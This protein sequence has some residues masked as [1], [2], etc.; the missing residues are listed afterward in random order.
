MTAEADRARSRGENDRTRRWGELMYWPLTLA[1][2][3]FLITY[4]VHVIGDVSGI[5]RG[6]TLSTIGV[7][8]IV[9]AADY[10]ITLILSHP[11]RRWFRTHLFDL[12][13]V[14]VPALRPIRLLGALTRIASMRGTAGTSIRA[15]LLIYGSGTALLLIWYIS[16]VVLEAERGAP[17]ATI[18]TFGDAVWWAFC[19]VTTVGYGDYVPVTVVGR[20]AAVFLMVGGVVLVGMI[21]A[22]FA[23]WVGERASRG[24]DEVRPA[25]RADVQELTKALQE[26]SDRVAAERRSRGA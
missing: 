26:A 15:R 19:T 3:L 4:T 9:F 6:F 18:R 16:L 21:V 7:I 1:A 22:T 8:Y 2:L 10:V 17:G 24:H 11:R 5:T 13:V 20:V 23:S 14:L 12:A 25:S